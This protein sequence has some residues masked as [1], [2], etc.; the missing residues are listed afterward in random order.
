VNNTKWG[1]L[2][3]KLLKKG[4]V[5]KQPLIGAKNVKGFALKTHQRQS[6]WKLQTFEKA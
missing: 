2:V 6:L 1:C 5:K 4:A 3:Y